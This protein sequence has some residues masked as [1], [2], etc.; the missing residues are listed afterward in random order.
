MTRRKDCI[1]GGKSTIKR[2]VLP[3]LEIPGREPSPYMNESGTIVAFLEG[4]AGPTVNPQLLSSGE[5]KC[6]RADLSDFLKSDGRFKVCQRI[7]TRPLVIKMTHLKDW[8]K[9]EDVK[10]AVDKYEGQGW[11][12]SD[13]ESKKAKHLWRWRN[14][15]SISIPCSYRTSTQ[16]E[17][18]RTHGMMLCSFPSC[19]R[20]LVLLVSS[21]LSVSRRT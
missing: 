4:L 14:F 18:I 16:V 13:A 2:K 17:R 1:F 11:S 5:S 12:Y 10:Y 6:K 7:L 19:V 15:S 21:G 9:A 20:C 8:A 3:V